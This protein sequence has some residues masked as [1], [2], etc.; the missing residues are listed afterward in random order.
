MRSSHGVGHV[1]GE[2]SWIDARLK[3]LIDHSYVPM[4]G[5]AI[6][7]RYTTMA[8]FLA[9]LLLTVGIVVG[10]KV[11]F[12]F[13]PEVDSDF[14]MAT[15][16]LVEGAPES[17]I[18]DVVLQMNDGLRA[19]D[20]KLSAGRAPAVENVFAYVL[21]GSRALFQVELA[22]E[23]PGRVSTEDIEQEWRLQV[24]DISGTRELKFQSSMHISGGPPVGFSLVSSSYAD[25]EQAAKELV[26]HL[27]SINGLYEVESTIY[28]G[29]DELK[30]EIRPEAEAFGVSLADLARQVREA[31]YGAEGA[32]RSA[33]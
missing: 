22:R 6:A 4:L 16:D 29:P 12:V 17:L 24:G 2:S 5:R 15:V 8:I 9:L 33:R 19:A 14:V 30:L 23:Q 31:F 11:R 20:A 18:Q 26:T 32:T 28:E 3:R 1:P 21:N 10:G 13:F 27:R 25:L 7:H